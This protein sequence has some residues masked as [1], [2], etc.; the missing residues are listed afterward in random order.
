MA[1][2]PPKLKR[3]L[4]G[5]SVGQVVLVITKSEDIMKTNI[6]ILKL[7]MDRS[8]G[9]YITA[10]QPHS[11]LKQ[12]FAKNGL[13]INHMF[14]IDCVTKRVEENPEEDERCVYVKS[15]GNLTDISISISEALEAIRG[16]RFLFM[17]NLSTLRI[18]NSPESLIRFLHFLISKI[19]LLKVIGIFMSAEEDRNKKFLMQ[20]SQFCDRTIRL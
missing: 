17:D 15:P 16:R 3:E 8:F 5:L 4:R 2:I 9:L 20:I 1:D 10:N 7:L 19:K 13:D 12:T 14:F 11:S 18:Y 6:Q